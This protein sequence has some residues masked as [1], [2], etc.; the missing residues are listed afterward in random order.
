MGTFRISRRCFLAGF[1]AAYAQLA[2][3]KSAPVQQGKP[4]IDI[5][6]SSTTVTGQ[7]LL[8][9]AQPL[10]DG[11]PPSR[12]PAPAAEEP[13]LARHFGSNAANS[14]LPGVLPEGPWKI[15][16]STALSSE[17]ASVIRAGDRIICQ[18]SGQWRLYDSAGKQMQDRYCG[19]TPIVIDERSATFQLVTDALGWEVRTLSAGE[20][21][22]QNALP[23]DETYSWP[24]LFRNGSRMVAFANVQPAF[25]HGPPPKSSALLQLIEL[26]APMELDA[27]KLVRN[28]KR[29]ETLEIAA[30][31][32]RAAAVNGS[33][34]MAAPDGLLRFDSDLKLTAAFSGKFT[35][36][37]ISL[38]ESGWA[39]IFVKVDGGRAVWMVTPEGVRVANWQ[40]PKEVDDPIQPPILGYDRRMY[41][42]TKAQLAAVDPQG[43]LLWTKV[44]PG[45]SVGGGVTVNGRVL[46]T[47]STSLLAFTPDGEHTVLRRFDEPVSSPAII[48]SHREILLSAG[49]QLHCLAI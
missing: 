15:K 45:G 30:E 37:Q 23:Y 40:L 43:R 39:C 9:S 34:T 12:P 46:V 27:S 22:F 8:Y 20:M 19:K 3:R 6:H 16:W 2:Q 35:P 11:A 47:S 5:V 33:V 31:N 44:V 41:L 38:D 24:V 17:G 14:R 42:L 28:L 13:F 26:T 36:T 18:W 48:T 7:K 21:V 1:P 25:R 29:F 32:S 49:K 10:R 4:V